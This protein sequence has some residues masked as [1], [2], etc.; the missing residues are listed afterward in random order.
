MVSLYL[1]KQIQGRWQ[2]ITTDLLWGYKDTVGSAL[3]NLA[4]AMNYQV[5]L[6]LAQL[7]GAA[8]GGIYVVAPTSLPVGAS[9]Q[10]DGCGNP[11]PW[12]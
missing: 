2:I 4:V 3:C 7:R 6:G 10:D 11:F 9:V 8:I 12:T 5:R 1:A